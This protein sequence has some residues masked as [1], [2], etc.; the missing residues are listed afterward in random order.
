MTSTWMTLV[1]VG[2]VTFLIRFSCLGLA[3]AT[4]AHPRWSRA[5]LRPAAAFAALV[6]PE[7]FGRVAGSQA[8]ANPRLLAG[9][10]AAVVAWRTRHVLLTI[11]SGWQRC[12]SCSTS[13]SVIRFARRSRPVYTRVGHAPIGLRACQRW[14]V[15]DHL[16][17]LSGRDVRDVAAALRSTSSE[18]RRRIRSASTACAR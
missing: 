13:P 12:T 1:A 9:A 10:V 17:Q 8:I 6:A 18:R 7:L 4:E 11:A 15:M 5:A 3:P 2:A 14:L 16:S